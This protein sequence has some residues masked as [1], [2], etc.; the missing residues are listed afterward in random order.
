MWAGWAV[1]A[2]TE[3]CVPPPA[4]AVGS[5]LPCLGLFAHLVSETLLQG[6]ATSHLA[7]MEPADRECR[8]WAGRDRHR[9]GLGRAG[10]GTGRMLGW[11][12]SRVGRILERAGAGAGRDRAA[13]PDVQHPRPLAARAGLLE[14]CR[15]CGS[16]AVSYLS[17]LQDPGTVEGADCSPVTTCLG[18]ISTIGEVGAPVGLV[19]QG[20]RDCATPGPSLLSRPQELRPKGLDVK[21]EELG[22][23]VD[24][25]MAATAAAI[26]TAAARIEVRGAM[27]R[28]APV[29]AVP[30]G[31]TG[32]ELGLCVGLST[33]SPPLPGDAEQGTGW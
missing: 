32:T 18:R 30:A 14:L 19:G 9:Q 10:A 20:Q 28:R 26:E 23:L 3:P 21:Q 16:E 33:A 7:P 11:A 8:P 4:T 31:T 24:K 1:P 12:G 6:S 27:C 2:G 13:G 5:L 29:G 22:D 17:A 15:Q 25:E